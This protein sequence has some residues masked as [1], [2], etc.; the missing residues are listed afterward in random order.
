MNSTVYNP[1]VPYVASLPG[2]LQTGQLIRIQ[3]T[4]NSSATCFSINLQN[5]SSTD[6]R[7]DVALHL[8]PVFSPPP[9]LVRNTIQNQQWGPEESHGSHFPFSP[10]QSFEIMILVESDHFKIAV[11]GQHFCEFRYR[12][13]LSDVSHLAIDGDVVINSIKYETVSEQVSPHSEKIMG[14]SGVTMP[15]GFVMPDSQSGGPPPSSGY[16]RPPSPYGVPS[17][18]MPSSGPGQSPYGPAPMSAPY[19]QPSSFPPPPPPGYPSPAHSPSSP[20]SYPATGPSP[21]YPG[22]AAPS[23]YPSQH[24]P[25]QNYPSQPGAYPSQPGAYPS[26]PG[27]Y[28]SQPGAYPSHGSYPATNPYPAP[29][30][31]YPGQ[32]VVYPVSEGSW[33]YPGPQPYYGQFQ[34]SEK[35]KGSSAS[36][37][38]GPLAAGATALA[39]TALLSQGS[40]Y[41]KHGKHLGPGSIITDGAAALLSGGK[42]GPHGKSSPIPIGGAVAG[43]AAALA[44]A[45]ML[46]KSPVG[47]FFK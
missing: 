1:S 43:G 29:P 30:G 15:I 3:G 7:S 45:Y 35:D 19:L 38:L 22:Q 8:S 9:R 34:G 27:A 37:F 41:G 2:R 31:G 12:L 16:G 24:Y 23:A 10:E 46:S 36:S 14:S 20:T 17:Y 21:M 13:P 44:G 32:S 33:S 6:R 25:S 40:K 5:G 39:G 42:H 28:P 47:G 11:N 4:P 18:S 26:Q